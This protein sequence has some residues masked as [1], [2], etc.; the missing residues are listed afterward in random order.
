[1][2]NR[3]G[4]SRAPHQRARTEADATATVNDRPSFAVRH[5]RSLC[6]LLP[7]ILAS[8]LLALAGGCNKPGENECK[9]A[10]E[11]IDRIT[12]KHNSSDAVAAAVR[13]CRAYSSRQA[14]SCWANAKTADDLA[15]CE[16]RTK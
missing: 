8:F 5:G 14:T 10:I 4:T 12:N 3:T 15:A 16:Q 11:N 13:K 6:R 1:M 9:A 2:P 7:A